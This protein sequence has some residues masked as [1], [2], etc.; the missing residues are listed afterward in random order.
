VSAIKREKHRQ[1][2]EM[3]AGSEVRR[4]PG[5]PRSDGPTG[6]G[7]KPTSDQGE[8]PSGHLADPRN[9]NSQG[10]KMCW[11][12][13]PSL[14]SARD[15]DDTGQRVKPGWPS[16]APWR[17]GLSSEVLHSRRAKFRGLIAD[18]KGRPPPWWVTGPPVASG[19]SPLAQQMASPA[20]CRLASNVGPGPANGELREAQ[21][22]SSGRMS[23]GQR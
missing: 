15:G 13:D 20:G 16:Y 22:S 14:A 5:Q 9:G 17:L 23:Q 8:G 18:E 12:P 6:T 21:P 2:A 10:R 4:S 1:I 19:D 7:S 11:L 3:S